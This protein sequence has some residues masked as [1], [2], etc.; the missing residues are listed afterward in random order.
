MKIVAGE[1]KKSEI[2]GPHRSGPHPWG[3]T[4]SGP[5]LFLGLAPH[6]SGPHH[7]TKNFGQKTGQNW[8]WPKLAGPKPRWPKMD[9]PKLDWPKLKSGWPKRDWPKSVSSRA[10]RP[11]SVLPIHRFGWTPPA[12]P[13]MTFCQPRSLGL[14]RS[15]PLLLFWS[16]P[17]LLT[18]PPPQ[19]PVPTPSLDAGT[20]T[21]THRCLSGHIHATLVHRGLGSTFTS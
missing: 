8:F 7:D 4:T 10:H 5:S 21:F 14:P 17:S 11:R 2:L 6:P 18:L 3:P 15:S 9:W 12:P 16:V 1:G 13:Q 19:Q 20:Q